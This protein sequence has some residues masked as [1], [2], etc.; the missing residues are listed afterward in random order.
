[1]SIVPRNVKV[2][3]VYQYISYSL[4]VHDQFLVSLDLAFI[5]VFE[6]HLIR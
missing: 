3:E 4:T 1:V 6:R 5:K 2:Y